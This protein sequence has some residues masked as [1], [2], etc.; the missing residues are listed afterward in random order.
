M[1]KPVIFEPDISSLQTTTVEYTKTAYIN[2]VN[3]NRIFYD[4]VQDFSQHEVEPRYGIKNSKVLG[5]I[6]NGTMNNA[7]CGHIVLPQHM[8]VSFIIKSSIKKALMDN[9]FK[10]IEVKSSITPSTFIFDIDINRCWGW[11]KIDMM[12]SSFYY[13][14]E[15][16]VKTRDDTY[17]ITGKDSTHPIFG[18]TRGDEWETFKNAF[19]NFGLDAKQKLANIQ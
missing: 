4:N 8:S 17:I 11:A 19:D 2:S 16:T 3:D 6:H 12:S 14:I 10:I 18:I 15:S 13:D 7:Y 9:G 5:S 1:F